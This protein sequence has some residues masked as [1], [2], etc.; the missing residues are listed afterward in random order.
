[1]APD[2]TSGRSEIHRDCG[3]GRRRDGGGFAG[4]Q[5]FDVELVGASWVPN[6]LDGGSVSG[7]GVTIGTVYSELL[8]LGTTKFGYNLP[9]VEGPVMQ[10]LQALQVSYR[11]R[12]HGG[13][14][15]EEEG[16]L[17]HGHWHEHDWRRYCCESEATRICEIVRRRFEVSSS[18]PD[19]S[20]VTFHGRV[21]GGAIAQGTG[22]C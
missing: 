18:Q 12:C 14:G 16:G 13:Q 21:P 10:A 20:R 19:P 3:R 6:R 7:K 4:S 17:E 2:S 5:T 22:N 11:G 15:E 1:M 8:G 9:E